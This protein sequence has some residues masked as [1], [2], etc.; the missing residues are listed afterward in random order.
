MI[1]KSDGQLF[2]SANK[3]FRETVVFVP[4][5]QGTKEK[6]KRHIQFINEIGFDA[7][8]F[9]LQDDFSL[10][11]PPLSKSRQLGFKHVYADQVTSHLD[12][13]DGQKILFVFSNPSASVIEALAARNCQDVRALICDSGPSGK[14]KESV[15]N[16]YS[17]VKP[18]GFFPVR[19]VL[20]QMFSYIWSPLLHSDL[21]KHLNSF[22]ANF[23]VL[24]IQGGQD[25]VIPPSHIDQVFPGTSSISLEKLVLPK[26]SHLT[27]LRDFPE[28]YKPVVERFLSSQGSPIL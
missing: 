28:A 9:S 15:R 20:T 4:F 3:R 24:S 12:Q 2:P 10:M 13:I 8:A 18:I 14:F 26:A 27:G 1:A 19:W 17:T 23:P 16:L 21:A 7:F 11:S 25:E 6:L 5:F 22:P